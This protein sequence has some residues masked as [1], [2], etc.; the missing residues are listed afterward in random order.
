M[1]RPPPSPPSPSPPSSPSASPSP[2]AS[3]MLSPSP[4]PSGSPSRSRPQMHLTIPPSPPFNP[5][6]P[7]P[8][9]LTN[10]PSPPPASPPLMSPPFALPFP[11]LPHR[12]PPK[13]AHRPRHSE[14]RPSPLHR[15]Y[16][17]RD[18]AQL[19]ESDEE[20]EGEAEGNT[21]TESSD[22]SKSGDGN[23]K[24][25]GK[26]RWRRDGEG[27]ATGQGEIGGAERS[28]QRFTFEGRNLHRGGF[29]GG[30]EGAK[31]IVLNDSESDDES[32]SVELDTPTKRSSS[33]TR[34][35]GRALSPG[36]R[37]LTTPTRRE[38]SASGRH[39]NAAS[40]R[41][42]ARIASVVSMASTVGW[43]HAFQVVGWGI[44][45]ILALVQVEEE[46]L[47]NSWF[48]IASVLDA[49]L[50]LELCVRLV[51][52]PKLHPARLHPLDSIRSTPSAR[53]HPLDSIRSTPSARLHPLDSISAL[54]HLP[55]PH[56]GN[57]DS[58]WSSDLSN[59]TIIVLFGISLIWPVYK[60]PCGEDGLWAEEVLIASIL[61]CRNIG[62]LLD[63][64]RPGT[65]YAGKFRPA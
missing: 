65:G 59:D 27:G 25:R 38:T 8:H 43:W 29:A 51:R 39:R 58:H 36:N 2:G 12:S 49:C 37:A 62:Q 46:C 55:A 3:P 32:E 63:Q 45:I 15:T 33:A 35:R 20:G 50:V 31:V 48:T 7:V 34:V 4:S 60:W 10:P 26:G 16:S 40:M 53:L 56:V 19:T 41:S 57:F 23:G 11:H 61:L 1:S 64:H 14:R 24:G 18:L 30:K 44:A 52:F 47:T 13:R 6:K 54:S 42:L 17:A 22:A 5:I 28:L 21:N 9:P